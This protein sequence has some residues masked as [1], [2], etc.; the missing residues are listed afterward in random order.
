MSSIDGPFRILSVVDNRCYKRILY[1]VLNHDP[2][3]ADIRAFL[4]RL[5]TALATRDLTLFGGH[6]RW[7]GTLSCTFQGGFRGC[8]ASNLYVSYHG[9]DKQSSLRVAVETV[10]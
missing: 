8:L 5:K 10:L 2:T 6:H 9:G 3:H 7:L 1:K 4:E